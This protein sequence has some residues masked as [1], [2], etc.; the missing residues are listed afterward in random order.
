M[1]IRG[2][3]TG[4]RGLIGLRGVSLIRRI[5]PT[6]FWPRLTCTNPS[7][8]ASCCVDPPLISITPPIALLFLSPY[9]THTLWPAPCKSPTISRRG[10]DRHRHRHQRGGDRGGPTGPVWGLRR[11]EEPVHGAQPAHRLRYGAS[12]P[13]LLAVTGLLGTDRTRVS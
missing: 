11:S 10:M 4:P 5:Y 9:R 2:G 12:S 1:Q 7:L 8:I 3:R 13:I 6:S